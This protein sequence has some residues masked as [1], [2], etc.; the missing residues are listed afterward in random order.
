VPDQ[1]INLICHVENP[2]YQWL[3]LITH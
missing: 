1:P 2:N 3:I